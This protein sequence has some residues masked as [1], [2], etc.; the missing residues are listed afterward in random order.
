VK[1]GSRLVATSAQ[2][3]DPT[4]IYTHLQKY[5]M[6]QRPERELSAGTART[7]G[8]MGDR[9]KKRYESRKI[10]L[11]TG[12]KALSYLQLQQIRGSNGRSCQP[13]ASQFCVF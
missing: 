11:L 7:P 4:L 5:G 10:L 12:W 6:G 1:V 2:L 13:D 9:N 3:E 8:A